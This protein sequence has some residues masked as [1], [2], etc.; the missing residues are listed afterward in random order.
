MRVIDFLRPGKLLVAVSALLVVAALGITLTRGLNFGLDFTGGLLLE[1][2][3]PEAVNPEGIRLRLQESGTE[4]AVVQNFGAANQVLIRLPATAA[5]A[6]AQESLLNSLRTDYPGI[7]IR[8][9][10]LVGPQ[11]GA[12]LAE[13][14]SLALLIALLLILAYVSVRFQWKLALG[15]VVALAHDVIIAVGFFSLFQLTFDLAV[16]AGLLAVI[17]YSLNDT[18][19]IFDRARENFRR[20]RGNTPA[21]VLNASLNQTL[22]R[23]LVTSLTTL[24]VLVSL[25]VLGGEALRGFSI[26]MVL[27]VTVGTYS[28]I[29]VASA[30]A[31]ALGLNSKDLAPIEEKVAELDELP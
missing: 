23:T 4:G 16:L 14:G 29:Y 24:L 22:R 30:V 18:I 11:V 3:F 2:A 27:G 21:Q 12:E 25:L 8:R 20:L 15:A 26:A 13:Q 17:G 28:S 9:V 10:E 5:V 1:V 19:V 7:D 6:S 31:L